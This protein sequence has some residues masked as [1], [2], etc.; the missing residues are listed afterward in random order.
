[1]DGEVR[2]P[3]APFAVLRE[4]EVGAPKQNGVLVRFSTRG[5]QKHH[6]QLSGKVHVKNF[7]PKKLRGETPPL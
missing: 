5:V 3:P 4:L 1:L 6:Q 2:S 7:L